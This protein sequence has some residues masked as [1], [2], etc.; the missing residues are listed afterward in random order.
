MGWNSRTV[1]A[2]LALALLLPVPAQA[3]VWWKGWDRA[4]KSA[5]KNFKKPAVWGPLAGAAAFGVTNADKYVSDWARE[6]Q[7][8][9]GSDDGAE[10]A[11]DRIKD[12]SITAMFVSSLA[13]AP[14]EDTGRGKRA[15]VAAMSSTTSFLTTE[16]LKHI[17]GE[18]ARTVAIRKAF[19]P[20]IP[21][22]FQMH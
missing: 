4:K 15:A 8:I 19:P 21:Q 1:A 12:V 5:W 22:T 9:Y 6:H 10:K 17:G 3:D 7:P 16:A 13:P 11:A 18:I 2:T 14:T 20:C